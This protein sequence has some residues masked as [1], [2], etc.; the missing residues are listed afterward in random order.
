M[1]QNNG[2]NEENG[3]PGMAL[4]NGNPGGN[5]RNNNGNDIAGENEENGGPGMALPNG[6]PGGN[7]RNNNGNDIAVPN[8]NPE[9]GSGPAIN[10]SNEQD[11]ED[12]QPLISM[13]S[14]IE[15][16]GT[17]SDVNSG[18]EAETILNRPLDAYAAGNTPINDENNLYDEGNTPLSVPLFSPD[19]LQNLHQIENNH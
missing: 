5:A 11:G 14:G 19:S 4:L 17:N 18:D 1:Q 8:V 10:S 6:N 2:E 15:E 16:L 7:A 9:R 12:N 13:T 3:G